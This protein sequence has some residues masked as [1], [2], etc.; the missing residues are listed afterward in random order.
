MHDLFPDAVKSI[1]TA[2]YPV[3]GYRTAFAG[4]AEEIKVVIDFEMVEHD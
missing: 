2:T 3:E 1:I 4:D